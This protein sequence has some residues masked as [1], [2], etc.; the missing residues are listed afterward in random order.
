MTPYKLH[1]SSFE[2]FGECPQ[3]PSDYELT[4]PMP[5][6][7]T[8]AAKQI[9]NCVF[10]TH[11]QYGE[12]VIVGTLAGSKR[13]RLSSL[14]TEKLRTFGRLKGTN[15]TLLRVTIQTML[16]SD[17]L[18][19]SEDGYRKLL[20]G[21]CAMDLKDDSKRVMV[22]LRERKKD[23]P[24]ITGKRHKLDSELFDELRILRKD[25]ASVHRVIPYVIFTDDVLK[26]MCQ[27]LPD[28]K[29][30]MLAVLQM[31]TEKYEQYGLPFLN[32]IKEYVLS[33][34]ITAEKE[35]EKK[36][37]CLK[38]N[39]AE[40]FPYQPYLNILQIRDALNA[41]KTNPRMKHI[42]CTPILDYLCS[43]GLIII[44]NYWGISEYTPTL[45]GEE[46][47]VRTVEKTVEGGRKYRVLEYPILV[48]RD[49]VR[50]F[51]ST[52]PVPTR[53][54]QNHGTA[55]TKE[56]DTTLR[57]EYLAGERIEAIAAAHGRTVQAIR[58]RL[59]KQGLIKPI[60]SQQ[61]K[62]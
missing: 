41:M 17:Y 10:E 59:E 40:I 48:Q 52:S 13:N 24:Q 43:S 45:P 9:I 4:N 16:E 60:Y 51:S 36:P 62:Q 42:S 37:F 56:E 8:D 21:K 12:N 58:A 29:E 33:Q 28:T 26:T 27:Y 11:G 55:W 14:G 23:T 39:D 50:H 31:D 3:E 19:Y 32:A 1:E 5:I 25:I 22:T 30:K 54:P 61:E 57:K 2:D 49:I 20:M 15:R 46:I 7:M 44:D 53:S 35:T 38:Q 18:Q 34:G 47:G 6:D